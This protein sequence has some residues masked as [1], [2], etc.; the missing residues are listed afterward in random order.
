MWP[1]R[2]LTVRIPLDFYE[3]VKAR[4]DSSRRSLGWTLIELARQGLAAQAAEE[5]RQLRRLRRRR[6]SRAR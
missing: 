4:A 3:E 2:R 6:R 5:R 1:G